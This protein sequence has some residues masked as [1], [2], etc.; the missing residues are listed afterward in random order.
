MKY[1]LYMPRSTFRI[2]AN[3]R[4][5][6]L[7]CRIIFQPN[8]LTMLFLFGK[9]SFIM[10]VIDISIT[11]EYLRGNC[12]SKNRS[13]KLCE[14]NWL[15]EPG[16]ELLNRRCKERQT[17][18]MP[19]QKFYLSNPFDSISRYCGTFLVQHKTLHLHRPSLH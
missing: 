8:M 6:I 1:S 2:T 17:K 12:F 16:I 14:W 18:E 19:S 15:I 3:I 4:F 5:G 7:L 13:R 9:N 10:H 11:S